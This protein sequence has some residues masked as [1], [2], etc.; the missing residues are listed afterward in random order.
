LVVATAGVVFAVV[1]IF[2]QLGFSDALFVSAVR[3]H[4]CL[5]ADLVLISPQ[6]SY[7]GMSKAFSQRRLYQA[8]ADAGVA[9]AT[10]LSFEVVPWKNRDTGQTRG[11][12]VLGLDSSSAPLQLPGLNEQLHRLRVSDAVLF[13]RSSRPE[14]GVMPAAL[15]LGRPLV[16]ELANRQVF[17]NGFFDLGTG[18]AVDGNVFT[19]RTTFLRLLPHRREGL[20]D[21]GLVRL[22]GGV[23]AEATRRALS[24]ALPKDVEVLTKQ[25]FIERE[26][27]Y[28][29]RNT[30]IGYV[31]TFGVIMG[32]FVGAVIVYQVLFVNVAD[33]LA[34]YATLKA[35][36]FTDGS[37]VFIVLQQAVLLAV[38]GFVPGL[39]L[40][41]QFYK[42]AAQGTLLPLQLTLGTCLVVFALT[43]LMCSVSGAAA[44]R[45]VRT[46]DPAEVFA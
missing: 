12:F 17:V 31:F 11:I 23:D 16:A 33:H 38:L 7:L 30:P 35:V 1:L 42:L 24:A 8:R 29:R 14:F 18:F 3:L 13:D 43:V 45:K 40:S 27:A 26:Q 19:E 20:I 32:F 5:D 36:G 46:A 41:Y 39:L 6:Y 2:M 25:G 44:L 28:W 37:L 15:P 34:E 21:I 10:A 22:R 4:R 9:S